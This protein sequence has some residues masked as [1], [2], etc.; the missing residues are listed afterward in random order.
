MPDFYVEHAL[1]VPL[2]PA[3]E[4]AFLRTLDAGTAR[5]RARRYECL[6][7]SDRR[8]LF[9]RVGADDADDVRA[10]TQHWSP[11]GVWI[12]AVHSSDQVTHATADRDDGLVDVIA[13]TRHSG[14]VDGAALLAALR[15]GCEWCLATL[16]VELVGVVVA[17]PCDRVLALFRAPDAEA[18]RQ[19]YRHLH[20]RF[21]RVSALRRLDE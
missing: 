13:E 17:P 20:G 9:Y 19:A 10:A 7:D 16:R 1:P 8:R 2:E 11:A 18:V 15:A 21:A 5:M 14:P 4:C 6:I 3:E 12:G